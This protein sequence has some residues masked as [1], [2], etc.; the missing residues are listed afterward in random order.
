MRSACYA[1]F[2]ARFA[3]AVPG[4]GRTSRFL[5]SKAIYCK[6][7]GKGDIKRMPGT[8]ERIVRGLKRGQKRAWQL[9]Y[10][11]YARQLWVAIAR[12]MPNDPSAI[13]DVM[14]EA[15]LEAARS[16]PNYDPAKGSLWQWLYGI[17]RHR[18]ARFYRQEARQLRFKQI[19]TWWTSMGGKASGWLIG[20]TDLQDDNLA[21]A[22]LTELVRRTLAEL[23]PDHALLLTARYLDGRSAVEIARE[24][25][26]TPEAVRAKLHR[27]RSRFREEY[28]KHAES[29]ANNDARGE[30]WKSNIK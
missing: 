1:F 6:S 29:R 9:L 5:K 20:E 16:A 21:R 13:G 24:S 30:I 15:F 8:D 25:G 27:A 23:S 3:F 26:C 28:L 10:D 7:T 19:Q 11:T 22:E 2:A 12:L 18:V 17:S 14:Q 4:A